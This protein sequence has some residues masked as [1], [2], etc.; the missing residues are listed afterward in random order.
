MI[1]SH[2][3]RWGMC[4]ISRL[5]MYE[6]RFENHMKILNFKRKAMECRDEKGTSD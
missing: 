2:M 1:R 6:S 4:Y 3:D 5:F